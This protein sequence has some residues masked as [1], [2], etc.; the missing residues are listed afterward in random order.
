MLF[1][2]IGPILNLICCLSFHI[3]GE[4][5]YSYNRQWICSE[6]LELI[7]I[8]I[9]DV[10]CIHMEEIYVLTAEITGFI[11]LCCAAGLHFE[12]PVLLNAVANILPNDYF[13]RHLSYLSFIPSVTLRMDMIHSSECIGLIMLMIVAYG[14]FRIKSAQPHHHDPHQHQKQS[15]QDHSYEST[16]PRQ[17]SHFS[18]PKVKQKNSVFN[19]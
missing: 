7:G 9:L 8:L 17:N 2:T 12:Y 15:N 3:T 5:S 18:T 11:I 1:L 4:H 10:S 19:V 16:A 13:Y 6:S 14:Q